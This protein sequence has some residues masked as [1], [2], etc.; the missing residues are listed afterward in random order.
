MTIFVG[1]TRIKINSSGRGQAI[2]KAKAIIMAEKAVAYI[3][4][5]SK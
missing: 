3:H 5:T 1:E 2:L 4:G